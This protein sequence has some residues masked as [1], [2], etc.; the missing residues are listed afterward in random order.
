MLVVLVPPARYKTSLLRLD[1]ARIN[2][3]AK[4]KPEEKENL[5]PFLRRMFLFSELSDERI[6]L[7][8]DAF[9]VIQLREGE[10]AYTE[11]VVDNYFYVV[12][13]GKVRQKVGSGKREREWDM[14]LA[15]DYFGGD[16]LLG[17]V[18]LDTAYA[19]V[20]S[21]VLRLEKGV[22][23]A[24]LEDFP[25]IGEMLRTTSESRRMVRRENMTWMGENETT[26]MITRR[27]E[28][29]LMLNLLIPIFL[30]VAAIPLMVMSF[31]SGSV[32]FMVIAVLLALFAGGLG[33][34][35][36]EDWRNDY[37]ILTSQRVLW[38]E[39]VILLYDSRE[40]APLTTIVSK[41]IFFNQLLR[42]FIDYG[43]VIVRTYTG[44][45]VFRRVA[46]PDLVILFLD[47]LQ[48][49]VREITKKEEAEKMEALIR[50]RL[51]LPPRKMP[52]AIARVEEKQRPLPQRASPLERFI[53]NFLKVRYELGETI[54]YRKHWFVLF[55]KTWKPLLVM[56]LIILALIYMGV[57][58]P[59]MGLVS[60]AFLIFIWVP[61]LVGVFIWGL[62]HYIDWRNDIYVVTMDRIFDIE[63]KPLSREDRKSAPLSNVL[64]LEHSRVGIIG[65]L[66][67]FGTVTINIGVEKF[68]FDNVYNPA[69]VQHEIFD[70]MHAQ[71]L[72][73]EEADA[74][75]ERERIVDGLT[76]YHRQVETLEESE[77]ESDWDI[78]S[79]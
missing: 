78:F 45:I 30:G 53:G 46:K 5:A 55:Q 10:R 35:L 71:R 67:N 62:Y 66:F 47:G 32:P 27:H 18:H 49:R 38:L 19:L 77:N 65:L 60:P 12:Y 3:M 9:E 8:A 40:E 57:S 13:E 2:V 17:P 50:E 42:R 69:Q 7:L 24:L 43:N 34:W 4:R 22:L 56:V 75:K 31:A 25:R 72:R 20:Y 73:K 14:L 37:F 48:A 44:S 1:R 68:T 41:D 16:I 58:F 63:R 79:G 64:S 59:G 23:L 29:F 61:V 11:G 74:R 54:T 21:R 15:G 39:K 36:W 70:R 26:Y 6:A 51:R 76:T 33:V 52:V 28:F